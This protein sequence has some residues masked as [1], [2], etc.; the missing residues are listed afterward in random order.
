MTPG[1]ADKRFG[2]IEPKAPATR[3]AGVIV[4]GE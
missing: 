3:A 1:H 4:S 2:L